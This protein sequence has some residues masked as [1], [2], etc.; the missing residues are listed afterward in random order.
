MYWKACSQSP[1]LIVIALLILCGIVSLFLGKLRKQPLLPA[2][3]IGL[4]LGPF[5]WLIVFFVKRPLTEQE[6]ADAFRV[7]KGAGPR[8][9]FDDQRIKE[10]KDELCFDIFLL[11]VGKYFIPAGILCGAVIAFIGIK[12]LSMGQM[13]VSSVFIFL[14]CLN[15]IFSAFAISF[16]TRMTR[17]ERPNTFLVATRFDY[18]AIVVSLAPERFIRLGKELIKK[19]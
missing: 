4:L 13:M 10:I 5:G 3:L 15:F 6:E 8:Q 19:F 2:F 14:S 18:F 16:L 12:N 1:I 9:F 11:T 17:E 7:F